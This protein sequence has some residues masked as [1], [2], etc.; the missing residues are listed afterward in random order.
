MAGNII[1][2]NII[3]GLNQIV[4]TIFWILWAIKFKQYKLLKSTEE[5]QIVCLLC[6][7]NRFGKSCKLNFTKLLQI[8]TS[9]QACLRK[10]M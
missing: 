5:S 7:K 6:N 2:N 4:K 3:H 1:S 10:Q 9:C 8:G